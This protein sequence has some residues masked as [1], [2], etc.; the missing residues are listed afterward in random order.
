MRVYILQRVNG[1]AGSF[2]SSAFVFAFGVME[3]RGRQE[4]E[5]NVE[6][7]MLCSFAH[8]ACSPP[9]KGFLHKE[10]MC[11]VA[12]TCPCSLDVIFLCQD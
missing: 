3:G 9:L 12:L 7:F 1:E 11:E 4:G 10:E 8:H 6:N 2:G 5:H